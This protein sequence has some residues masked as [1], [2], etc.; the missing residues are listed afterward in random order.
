MGGGILPDFRKPGPPRRRSG[1][2]P[3]SFLALFVPAKHCF[4]MQNHGN[5]ARPGGGRAVPVAASGGGQIESGQTARFRNSP[6]MSC[7]TICLFSR[8]LRVADNGCLAAASRAGLPV[9]PVYIHDGRGGGRRRLGGR[10]RW[11]LHHSLQD[12]DRELARLGSR[13][14]VR[15]GSIAGEIAR[16]LSECRPAAVHAM[17][18]CTGSD[19]KRTRFTEIGLCK[20]RGTTDPA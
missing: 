6:P 16:L 12:L 19:G 2:E 17:H 5:K 13:L 7:C 9:L 3:G 8:N 4:N 14:I 11:W 18:N 15:Q 20:S 10:S 1:I